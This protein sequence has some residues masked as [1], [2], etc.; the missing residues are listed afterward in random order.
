MKPLGSK[1]CSVGVIIPFKDSSGELEKQL[2]SIRAQAKSAE[3]I[4]LVDDGSSPAEKA[5]LAEILRS[6]PEVSLL[7]LAENIGA[8]GACNKGLEAISTEYVCFL[9]ANDWTLPNFFEISSSTLD[10]HP[11]CSVC[12]CDPYI[13][14]ERSRKYLRSR[15][16]LSPDATY[17]NEAEALRILQRSYFTAQTNSA[18]FRTEFVR[19][20]GGMPTELQSFADCFLV[21][22]AMLS[23]GFCYVPEP[24]GVYVERPQG[25]SLTYRRDKTA[26]R[27][28][29]QRYL[30]II[31]ADT[32]LK[33]RFRSIGVSPTHD[34]QA[35]WEITWRGDARWYLTAR[36]A[37]RCM[38]YSVWGLIRDYSPMFLRNRVRHVSGFFA[39][40]RS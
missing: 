29:L 10:G 37:R 9:S 31:E 28:L 40:R 30:N 5:R 39:Q 21:F 25:Y 22:N 11:R 6:F 1:P 2:G 20:A 26:K 27:R 24:L 19:Q 34:L 7:T 38:V 23:G 33:D 35:L 18:L 3:Q 14:F 8:G 36:L 32:N 4:V 15:L 12:I 13:F 16:G 17:F